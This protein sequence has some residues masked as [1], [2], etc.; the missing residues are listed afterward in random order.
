MGFCFA[1]WP[2][3]LCYYLF[4]LLYYFVNCGSFYCLKL[5]HWI[6]I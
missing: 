4:L 6:L 3:L 2:S 1:Y 5:C